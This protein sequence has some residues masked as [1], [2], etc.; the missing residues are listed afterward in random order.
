MG[1]EI[2]DVLR[3]VF[4]AAVIAAICIFGCHRDLGVISNDSRL[5]VMK[6]QGMKR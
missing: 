2:S 6:N 3:F 5:I 1:E 4:L